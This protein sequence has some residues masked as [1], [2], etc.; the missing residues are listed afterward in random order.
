M[1]P[2]PVNL[3]INNSGH[4]AFDTAESV[5]AHTFE[6]NGEIKGENKLTNC[7]NEAG[8]D[9]DEKQKEDNDKG[10]TDGQ[11]SVRKD[12]Q[13]HHASDCHDQSSEQHKM[14]GENE[15]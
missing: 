9:S 11:E 3:E 15:E 2:A 1:A 14:T 6:T 8:E 13:E 4:H 7:N 12:A 5:P 10:Q